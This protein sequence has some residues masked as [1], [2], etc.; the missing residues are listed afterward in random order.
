MKDVNIKVLINRKQFTQQDMEVWKKQRIKKAYKTLHIKIPQKASISEMS[1]K[2]TK[3]KVQL[4]DDEIRKI[5]RKKLF[6]SKY[7]MKIAGRLSG[8]KRRVART[9]I[10]AKGISV[11]KFSKLL[12]LL[13][14]EAAKEHR[15]VNLSVYPEHYVLTPDKNGVLEVIETTGNAPV[16]VQFFITFG[17]E[18]GLSEPK[19]PKF[20]YQSAGVAKLDD[21]T[22]I[23]G[24]RHQFRDTPAGIECRLA[25]EFPVLCPPIIVNSHQKHLAVEF[26]NWLIWIIKNQNEMENFVH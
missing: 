2:L 5:L 6:F 1:D 16:P 22:I 17:D 3:W 13:M 8:K 9:T 25:V 24:V 14:V 20:T 15:K 18:S 10:L 21:G 7:V 4:S 23:G 26:T 12:D 11:D 19:N